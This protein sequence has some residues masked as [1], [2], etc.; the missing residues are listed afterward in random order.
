MVEPEEGIAPSQSTEIR[1]TVTRSA[2]YIGVMCYDSDPQH[3]VSYTMQ[4]DADIPLTRARMD[5]F[6]TR[7][8]Q[9]LNYVQYDNQTESLGLNCRLRWTCRSLLD[10]FVVYN[11]NWF[12]M[13]Q[14]W[15]SDLNQFL[16]KIQYS[17]RK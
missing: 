3:I 11:R 5:V 6:V 16:V 17:R 9:I 12:D 13:E 14:R 4:R 2:W 1:L 7:N 8:F 15:L 10:V